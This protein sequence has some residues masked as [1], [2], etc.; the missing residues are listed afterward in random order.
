MF[1]LNAKTMIK[2]VKFF[3]TVFFLAGVN[4]YAQDSSGSGD[5]YKDLSRN[6][7]IK[8]ARFIVIVKKVSLPADTVTLKKINTDWLEK[9]DIR[10][11]DKENIHS[12]ADT[13]LVY[14][15]RKYKRAVKKLIKIE[16]SS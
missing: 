11:V 10:T 1:Y 4:L 6:F 16:W 7:D 15:N 5:L 12:P 8:A 13:V 2:T 14:V 9:V 3:L